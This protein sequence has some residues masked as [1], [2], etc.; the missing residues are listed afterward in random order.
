MFGGES[1][2]GNYSTRELLSDVWMLDPK[3]RLWTWIA[4]PNTPNAPAR[5]RKGEVS[6]DNTPSARSRMS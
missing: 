4:G 2:S 6:P 1:A 5:G 3:T